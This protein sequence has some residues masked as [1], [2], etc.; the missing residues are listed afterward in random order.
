MRTHGR[1]SVRRWQGYP[2]NRSRSTPA[3]QGSH[4]NFHLGT[5]KGCSSG[6][7]AGRITLG[8][9]CLEYLRSVSVRQSGCMKTINHSVRCLP[10][11][12]RI[13][14]CF[15]QRI[16]VLLLITKVKAWPLSQQCL[17]KQEA[18]GSLVP[19]PTTLRVTKKNPPQIRRSSRSLIQKKICLWIRCGKE[20]ENSGRI[21]K[22][23]TSVTEII[24]KLIRWEFSPVMFLSKITELI[25][26]EL[27]SGSSLQD[28]VH[29]ISVRVSWDR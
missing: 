3:R 16:E 6:K 20:H 5:T 23:T 26:G 24:T 8:E 22:A 17:E 9:P 4:C 25:A 27:S 15:V 11:G 19:H 2:D 12:Q 28:F 1:R 13:A 7:H 14:T 10:H 21:H 29:G 18:Q